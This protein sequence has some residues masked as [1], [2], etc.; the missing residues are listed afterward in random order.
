MI[1]NQDSIISRHFE[2]L[3]EELERKLAFQKKMTGDDASNSK[4]K[5]LMLNNDWQ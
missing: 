2:N 5:S 3:I 1:N 4:Q